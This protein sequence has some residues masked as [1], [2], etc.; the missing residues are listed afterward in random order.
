MNKQVE[1]QIKQIYNAVFKKV[2]TQETLDDLAK[3]SI[4]TVEL[5]LAKLQSSTQYKTFCEKF[6]KEL[7]KKG[8]GSQRGIWRKYFEAAKKVHY[9]AL[10]KTFSNYEEAVLEK[11]VQNNFQMIKS[12]PESIMKM[13]NRKYTSTL[14]EEVAKGTLSR[15]S[16]RKQL[17]SHGVKN[18]ALIARTE[19][20]KLQ[21]VILENRATNLGSVAYFWLA[22]NDRRTRQSHKNMD[23]VLVFWNFQ[24]P[25]LDEMRGHAGEFPN[26]RCTPQPILD[27]DDLTK[28]TYRVYNYTTDTIVVKSKREVIE[29]LHNE[30]F[31]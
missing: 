12:I 1:R 26:C 16:F 29:M 30:R 8:L 5:K 2:F 25:L 21:T 3:G 28:S 17:A 6:A 22:S 24:K 27:D 14:I 4:S 19:T 10:P 9:V 23:G 13:M 7:A 18:A 31:M 20:A 11:A 15:G